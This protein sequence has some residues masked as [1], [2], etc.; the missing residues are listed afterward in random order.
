MYPM[1]IPVAA[2]I[3]GAMIPTGAEPVLGGTQSPTSDQSELSPSP[4]G[5]PNGAP[6]YDP[7]QDE[8]AD[9]SQNQQQKK[10]FIGGLHWKTQDIDLR[11]Y[12][13]TF[14]IVTDAMVRNLLFS[15]GIPGL[16]NYSMFIGNNMFIGGFL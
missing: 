9:T 7:Y 6:I 11:N 3:P 8:G 5:I 15:H 12:F 10:L 4:N 2:M 16:Q 1:E 14:G 13:S